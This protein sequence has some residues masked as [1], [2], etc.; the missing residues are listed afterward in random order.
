MVEII[1]AI[2]PKSFNDLKDHLDRISYH[3]TEEEDDIN[4]RFVQVDVVDGIFASSKTWPFVDEAPFERIVQGEEGM[5]FWQEFDFEFDCMISE[6]RK[7]IEK[8]IQAGAM[9]LVLHAEG[10]ELRKTLDLLAPYREGTLPIEIGIALLPTSSLDS[11][12]VY[13]GSYDYV[14]VMGIEKVGFQGSSFDDRSLGLI[15]SL[16]AK[17]PQLTI[18][19]DGGVKIQNVREIVAAGCNRLIV[20]SA[21]FGAD[22]AL[23]ALDDLTDK[24]N[25]K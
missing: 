11:I 5:P 22:D 9:R 14:Q 18:Q 23:R 3:P 15:T 25:K 8:F 24:A 19:I 21:V 6:P 16:R 4:Y 2:L 1:P 13:D 12:D 17:Y 10:D 7:H 20:G